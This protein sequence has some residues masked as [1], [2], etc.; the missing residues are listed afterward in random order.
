LAACIA[1][2]LPRR[3]PAGGHTELAPLT[4]EPDA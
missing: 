2:P 3:A 1:V 4:A